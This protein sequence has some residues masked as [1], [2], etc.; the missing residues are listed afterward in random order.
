[1]RN[2]ATLKK[3][4]DHLSVS[5]STVSRALKDHQDVSQETKRRVKE[6]AEM[7]DYEPNGFAINLRKKH[8]DL[9]AVIV[10]EI[11]SYFYHSF[12]EAVEEEAR[13][14]GFAIMILQ[15]RNN[16]EVESGNLRL[17]R[18]NHVAGVFIAVNSSRDNIQAF[19]KMEDWDIPMVFFDKVP[20]EGSFNKVSM[21]DEQVGR[22]AAE[23]MVEAGYQKILAIMGS[24]TLSITN[25]RLKGLKDYLSQHSPGTRLQVLH[26][27]SSEQVIEL[28]DVHRESINPDTVI[29]SMSDEILCGTLKFLHRNNITYPAQTG[30]LTISNG[31]FPGL[32]HPNISYV[33]TNGGKL[34]RLAF[35]RMQEIMEGK[36]F[37]RENMLDC[38]Y[39]E[40]ESM[41]K[42]VLV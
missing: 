21:A 17:C 12:I 14:K 34:G 9:F 18:I 3:I 29:F 13:Q 5:I 37:I 31:F 35:Q 25:R 2:P 26:A 32:F 8:S 6:L 20:S 22:T 41:K 40:G 23:K 28:L 27:E 36:K 38:Q 11:S 42:P 33:E 4:S 16:A 19:K 15:S 1:M 30:L 10:P 24:E 7:L 39:F